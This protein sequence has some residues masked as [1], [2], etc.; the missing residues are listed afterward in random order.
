[1]RSSTAVIVA[2]A[3][4]L[5]GALG[6]YLWQNRAVTTL[7]GERDTAV[8]EMNTLKAKAAAL[9]TQN[10]N[11]TTQKDQLTKDLESANYDRNALAEA[12]QINTS[13]RDVAVAYG[14]A[15]ISRN[16]PWMRAMMTPQLL[17]SYQFPT[18]VPDQLPTRYAITKETKGATNWTYVVRVWFSF[19]SQGEVG[20]SDDT[21]TVVKVGTYYKISS[22]QHASYIPLQSGK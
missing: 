20:Y 16:Q 14:Q 7:S 9:E 3:A 5:M 11:L 12:V 15:R 4:L 19:K 18:E 22:L 13:A 8:V 17:S 2:V 6:A 1:M 21:L 10:K